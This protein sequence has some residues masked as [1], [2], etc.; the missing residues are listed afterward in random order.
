M[1][2]NQLIRYNQLQAVAPI[3]KTMSHPER[4]RIVDFL[5]DE[6]RAVGEIAEAAGIAQA[7]T[8]QHLSR[9]KDKGVVASRRDKNKRYYRVVN[10]SVFKL[11]E[12]ITDHCKLEGVTP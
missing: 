8:S 11:L 7:L 3:L 6:E 9:L 4:L 2:R 12:C 5:G 1:S 10:R